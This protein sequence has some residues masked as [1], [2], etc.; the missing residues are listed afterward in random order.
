MAPSIL[1]LAGPEIKFLEPLQ[2][3]ST[4]STANNNY[5]RLIFFSSSFLFPKLYHVTDL[6]VYVYKWT[7]DLSSRELQAFKPSTRLWIIWRWIIE[8]RHNKLFRPGTERVYCIWELF[9]SRPAVFKLLS[10]PIAPR[11]HIQMEMRLALPSVGSV[12]ACFNDGILLKA[13]A[14]LHRS[15]NTT[16]LD[17]RLQAFS[18]TQP[19]VK[20]SSVQ[21]NKPRAR[22]FAWQAI[23]LIRSSNCKVPINKNT[24][25]HIYILGIF[26]EQ[27]TK[28]KDRLK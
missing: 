27:R 26:N 20:A 21:N 14:E 11:P 13:G 23:P 19:D 24:H 9:K 6:S 2:M 10:S 3:P 7:H 1:L 8:W 4:G 18:L 15:I 17:S 28:V 16:T 25:Y 22:I 5:L 12:F